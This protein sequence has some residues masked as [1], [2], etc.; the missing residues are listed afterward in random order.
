MMSKNIHDE[1][2]IE[3]MITGLSIV[4]E[5]SFNQSNKLYIRKVRR[6]LEERAE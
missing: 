3:D 6:T 2:N 5:F 4:N 1:K